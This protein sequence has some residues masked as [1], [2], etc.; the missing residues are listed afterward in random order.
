LKEGETKMRFKFTRDFY[1]PK[2]ATKVSDKLSDAVAYVYTTAR[3]RPAAAIFFGKQAKPVS[4]YTYRSETVRNNAVGSAFESRRKSLAFKA[5]W[6][7]QKKAYVPTAKVGDIF[8]TCWGYDQTNREFF[9]IVSMT[10]KTAMVREIA[11]ERTYTN[12][13][14]GNAVPLPGKFV[15]EAKRVLL[16]YGG[17]FLVNGHHASPADFTEVAGVKAYKTVGW[18]AYA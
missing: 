14:Q 12:S 15:G 1:I 18:T 8:V 3:E 2:G 4:H 7:A 16:T 11:S 9:E 5:D 10:A 6:K 13:M 17:G